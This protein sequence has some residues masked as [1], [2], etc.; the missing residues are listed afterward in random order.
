[1]CAPQRCTTAI[2]GTSPRQ[3]P[4]LNADGGRRRETVADPI[5]DLRDLRNRIGHHHRIW[6]LPCAER[7]DQLLDVAGYIDPNLRAWIVDTSTAS[8]LI[9]S[10]PLHRPGS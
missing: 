3:P 6:P 7:H 8:T 9:A 5:S 2:E 1:M 4:S 10:S